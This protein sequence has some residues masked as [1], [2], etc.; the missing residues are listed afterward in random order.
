[1]TDKQC[2]PK[3]KTHFEFADQDSFDPYLSRL[4]SAYSARPKLI[5]LSLVQI[6]M[7]PKTTQPPILTCPIISSR[8]FFLSPWQG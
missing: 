3:D 6:L 5:F 8:L 7:F 2:D 4:C 1:M